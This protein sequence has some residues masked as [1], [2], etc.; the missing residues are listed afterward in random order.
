MKLR[1]HG[2][3]GRGEDETGRGAGQTSDDSVGQGDKL[4]PGHGVVAVEKVLVC[5]S[6]GSERPI[7]ILS[8]SGGWGQESLQSPVAVLARPP[9]PAYHQDGRSSRDPSSWRQYLRR[10]DQKQ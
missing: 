5:H 2:E 7:E 10:K 8:G 4:V 6:G 9:G 3:V 1:L